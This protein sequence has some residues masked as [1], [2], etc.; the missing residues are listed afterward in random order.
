MKNTHHLLIAMPLLL[1]TGCIGAPTKPSDFY[2]L[3][4]QPG[5]PVDTSGQ[6][7]PLTVELGPLSLPEVYERPQIVTRSAT[8]RISL[9]E[10][11]RWGGELGKDLARV[12]TQNLMTRLDT[13]SIVPYPWPSRYRP[14]FQVTVQLFRFDGVLGEQVELQGIWRILDGRDGCELAADGFSI[15]EATGGPGYPELVSA[16]SRGIATLSQQL[17]ERIAQARPGCPAGAARE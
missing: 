13:D 6:L 3:N 9:A 15:S 10:F 4:S 2:V 12:L 16:M 7:T 14:Q 5:T 17:A 1:L 8:N 11:D